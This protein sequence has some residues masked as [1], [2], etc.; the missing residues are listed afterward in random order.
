QIKQGDL[1]YMGGQVADTLYKFD[2]TTGHRE[3]ISG[4]PGGVPSGDCLG[5][6]PGLPGIATIGTG[7]IWV[8]CPDNCYAAALSNTTIVVVAGGTAYMVD[9]A[10]G[11]RSIVATSDDGNGPPFG[12]GAMELVAYL[13]PINVSSIGGWGLA[14]LCLGIVMGAQLGIKRG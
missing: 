13:P 6:G 1:L 14:V 9:V 3:V 2:T 8:S 12:P 7:P 5:R 11:N 10:T 4:C